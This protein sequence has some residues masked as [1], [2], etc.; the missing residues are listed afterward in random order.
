MKVIIVGGVA[1]GMS[2]ATRLRRLSEDAQIVV[3]ERGNHVSFANCGL[4]YYVGGLIAERDA[5]LLQTPESLAARFALDVRVRSEVVAIDTAART[6]TIRESVA[7]QPDDAA[8]APGESAREYTETYDELVLSPGARPFVPP[9]P[10]ADRALTLRDV[11]DV[12]RLTAAT[13]GARS[14]VIVGGGFIGIE[15]AE[16]L[17]H[18]GLDVTVVEL[19]DQVLAPLDPEMTFHV[20][21]TLLAHDVRLE[22]GRSVSGIEQGKVLLDDGRALAAD[23]VVMAIGV[24]PETHLARLAGAEIGATGGIVVDEDLRT[25]VE[26]VYALGDA[27]QKTDA[28]TGEGTL[29]PLANLANRHGRH[30]ADVIMGAAGAGAPGTGGR[31]GSAG[32]AVVGLFDLVVASTGWNEKRLRRAGRPATIIHTHPANHAGYYPGAQGMHLK[33]L[34]DPETDLILG[35]QAVGGAGVDKRIDVL[36]TAMAAG[37]TASALADL[38]L[39]YAPQFG[40]AKD[41]VNML[42]YI[43]DNLRSGQTRT[44]QWHELATALTAVPDDE[45]AVL[46]DVRTPGEHAAGSIP[47][48]VNIPLDDLRDRASELAG[49][50]VVV[51]CAVG[52]RGHTAARVLTGLGVDVRNLDGGMATWTAATSRLGAGSAPA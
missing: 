14:A 8:T 49:R 7:G 47:G 42:G 1:G 16:N 18:R 11:D 38:E 51:H 34:V 12:D 10:G 36:A 41:P 27:A 3:L 5:L 29:I 44:L 6:V 46:V 22:L 20:E 50:R 9:I 2:A 15:L 13:A 32:T 39:A 28:L 52:Q 35:A 23:L 31:R 37:L 26:H 24:R 40:S 21:Q 4:P 43:A 33:L 45:P 30:V 48:A 19:A 17:C 25:S